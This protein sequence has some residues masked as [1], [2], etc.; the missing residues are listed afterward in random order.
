MHKG[1]ILI[2]GGTGLIGTVVKREAEIRGYEVIVLSRS[3]GPGKIAW[4]PANKSIQTEHPLGFDAI[5]NLAGSS[6]AA[7][8]WTASRKLDI[9][10]SRVDS[11]GTIEQYL[12]SGLLKTSVYIGASGVGIFG[13]RGDDMVDE[14]TSI[15]ETNDW[16]IQTT[17]QW[18]AAHQRIR[19]TGIRTVI[20]RIG[21]VLTKDGGAL[22]EVLMPARF[23]LLA[24]FGNGRQYWPWIHTGHCRYFFTGNRGCNV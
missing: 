6:I 3:P 20:T 23:G 11:A 18:E 22:K 5:I 13:S 2:A 16:L 17:R 14:H 12:K 10:Q 24:Y 4:N 7:G 8:R 21:L 1:K 19:D 9:M 15:P